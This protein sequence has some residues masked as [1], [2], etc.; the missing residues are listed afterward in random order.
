[1]IRHGYLKKC[2]SVSVAAA[3][4]CT[5]QSTL[6]AEDLLT[7][8]VDLGYEYYDDGSGGGE[9]GGDLG[10]GDLGGGDLGG[11]EGELIDPVIT[12]EPTPEPTIDPVITDTPT[13]DPTIDPVITDT[14]TPDP[15]IDPVITDTPMPEP[16][17]EPVITDT[18]TPEPT[19]EPVI[20][21]T[22]TPE[23]TITDE[24]LP[25]VEP[26][27]TEV[28]EETVTPTPDEENDGELEP[29][30]D[31]GELEEE[32]PEE[33]ESD[34]EMIQSIIDRIAALAGVKI[35]EEHR[36]EIE[37]IRADYDALS[38]A[39]KEK[40]TNFSDLLALEDALAALPDDEEGDG[41]LEVDDDEITAITGSPVYYTNM[42]SNLH[43]GKEFYLNS[44]KENYQLS[45]SD[46][47]AVVMDEIE[48]EY[49][50]K[51]H[52]HDKKDVENLLT[53]TSGDSLLARNWQDILAIYVYE[54][55]L[56][57][58]TSY[59]LTADA[60]P[61]LA[62]LFAEMNPIVRSK[63][64][65]NRYAYGDR[66]INYYIK[67]NN[68][69]KEDREILKKYVETDCKLLCAVVTASHG[70]VRESVGENV[71]EERVNVICA[72]YSL[73]GKV[74]YF[75][76][77]KSVELGEDPG[78]GEAEVVTAEGSNSTGTTRAFG[79][80]CSGFVTWAV[81]NGY[82]DQDMQE[83][84]GDGTSDQWEKANVV[85]ES[86]AQ[87]GDLVFQRGPESGSNNHVGILC[88]K[89]DAG[90]W[91]AVHCSSGKNG[92]TVGEAYG[93]SFRYIRQPDFYPTE[94][95][96][97]DMLDDD[98]ALESGDIDDAYVP[99]TIDAEDDSIVSDFDSSDD[100]GEITDD[101]VVSSFDTPD[102]SGEL[103]DDSVVSYF[104]EPDISDVLTDD[105]IVSYFDEPDIPDE[106]TDDSIVS[107]FDEPD[108]PDELTD[109]SVV[110]YFDMTDVEDDVSN[111]PVLK[112]E[113]PGFLVDDSVVELF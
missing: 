29:E 97:I 43:A 106:L 6:M 37:G 77:G 62:E 85:S 61:R 5:S 108:A 104:D 41:E 70:F 14:P 49:K 54:E 28:P 7:S 20:T 58:E 51:N 68:V 8:G 9:L 2:L 47:F 105:S 46:D 17:V 22:P 19:V 27:I 99:V 113:I 83:T 74:G 44:L 35:T 75:W 31:D 13:P 21:D 78:W 32:D 71:S 48:A 92:V 25:T 60:K 36:E 111:E 56:K 30:E 87:P 18:P 76:G 81:I 109:D 107:Y 10:G 112:G 88:G 4:I 42:V 63:Y 103:T 16:T 89:T 55:S 3:M 102:V 90:D 52:L 64:N 95:E 73:V 84:I 96:V 34:V 12:D 11:G 98:L 1:M 80:D 72:A 57:G 67:K 59:E 15:T 101:S 39:D 24:P 65:P 45:F 53:T 86:D 91:I 38:E 94:E 50:E 33:E 79:L 40:V 66:H 93:A 23:P 110:S 26:T 100:S 69:S 82:Q